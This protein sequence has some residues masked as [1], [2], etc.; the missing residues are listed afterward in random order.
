MLNT[1]GCPFQMLAQ[2]VQRCDGSWSISMKRELYCHN[3]PLTEDIY[4]S[5]SSI[6]QVPED[7]LLNPASNC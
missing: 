3:H 4:K 5:Y 7:S 2:L 6:R 1:T